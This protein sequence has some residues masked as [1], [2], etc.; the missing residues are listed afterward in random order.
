[1]LENLITIDSLL[2]ISNQVKAIITHGRSNRMKVFHEIIEPLF[3]GLQVVVNDYYV[4]FLN[5]LDLVQ[6]A[7]KLELENAVATI[8]F[9]R[10]QLLQNRINII[11]LAEEINMQI[12]DKYIAMFAAKVVAFFQSS[13]I[14]SEP[15]SHAAHLIDLLNYV[16]DGQMTKAE[17]QHYIQIT[18][19]N[20]EKSYI[21]IA[22]S[23]AKVQLHCLRS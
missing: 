18:L 5:A 14:V 8:R 22:Q 6:K 17:L 2:K 9:Q 3:A 11:K 21:E 19:N 20:F 7:N 13:V 23:Y 10:F 16:V 15:S 12:K 1:M 4:L